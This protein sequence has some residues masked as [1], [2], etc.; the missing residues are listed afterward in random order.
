MIKCP[1]FL[2][3]HG[4]TITIDSSKVGPMLPRAG[5]RPFFCGLSTE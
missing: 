2:T 5:C 4:E 3:G 1:H